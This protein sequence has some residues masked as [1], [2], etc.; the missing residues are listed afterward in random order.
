MSLARHHGFD[1]QVGIHTGSAA[2]AV[3]G[4][5]RAFYCIYGQTVNTAS[6]LCKYAERGQICCSQGFVTCLNKE[7]AT[8]TQ[9]DTRSLIRFT[10]CG[11]VLMKGL[12]P[13]EV[14]IMPVVGQVVSP[15]CAMNTDIPES[16]HVDGFSIFWPTMKQKR[17]EVMRQGRLRQRRMSLRDMLRDKD[18]SDE[19]LVFLKNRR[20]KNSKR[21]A[22]FDDD[23]TE[24]HYRQYFVRRLQRRVSAGIALHLLGIIFHLHMILYSEFSYDFE[25]LGPTL[26]YAYASVAMLLHQ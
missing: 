21:F 19:S 8:R 2:G 5:L 9:V 26:A 16:F 11:I 22:C 13:L 15:P 12:E 4:S 10:P 1:L 24:E 14:F 3:I 25:I 17:G 7:Q 6:R 23:S 18:L 20:L